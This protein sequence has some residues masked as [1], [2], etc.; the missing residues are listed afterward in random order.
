MVSCQASLWFQVPCMRCLQVADPVQHQH[1]T[2]CTAGAV[3]NLCGSV[4]CYTMSWLVGRTLVHAL[5]P[6][7]LA[8]YAKEVA[9]RRAALFNYVVI[10]RATPVGS[11]SIMPNSS[12][13]CP[14]VSVHGQCS[15]FCC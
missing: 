15:R 11:Q 12:M 10:L 4:S 7:E 13:Q 8:K 9:K 3:L 14:A 2:K 5:Y 6:Q 1:M